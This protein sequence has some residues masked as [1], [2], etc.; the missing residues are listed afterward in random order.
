MLVF[1]VRATFQ[2]ENI[3]ATPHEKGRYGQTG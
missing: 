2:K 1:R 3:S